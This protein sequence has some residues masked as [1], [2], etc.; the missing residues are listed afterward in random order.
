[1][2]VESVTDGVSNTYLLG[3]KFLP[4]DHY[5]D[6]EDGGDN[7]NAYMGFNEDICRFGNTQGNNNLPPMQ[8]TPGI[9]NNNIFGSCHPDGFGMAFCDGSVHTISYSIDIVVHTHLSNRHDGA[10]ID[11]SQY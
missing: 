8:D 11:Q 3:E 9:A 6:G 1:M 7:E 10:V 4:T 5:S 2:T